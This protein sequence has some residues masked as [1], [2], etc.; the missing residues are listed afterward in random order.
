M[1]L[2]GIAIVTNGTLSEVPDPQAYVTGPAASDSREVV[3]GGMFAAVTG[4]HVD[5]HDFAADAAEAGAVCV[6][7]SRPVGVPA[8]IVSD[9]VAALGNLAQAMLARIGSPAVIALTGSSGKTS[10]KDLL[11][12]VLP[13]LGPTV[14]TPRSFNTE[15]GLP[16]T[17]LTADQSTRYLVLEMGR[18]TRA[19]SPTSPH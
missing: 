1:T 3:P 18:A 5:G 9:V 19:T 2:A 12:Q 13:G 17:V 7:A 8:V 10:T 14:A 15:I 4:A 6:L 11:A 16:L